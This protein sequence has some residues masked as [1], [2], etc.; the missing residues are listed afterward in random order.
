M[1][2]SCARRRRRHRHGPIVAPLAPERYKVQFTVPRGT[3]DKLR[4]A[5]DLLRHSIPDGDLAAIFDRALTLLLSDLEPAKRAATARPRVSRSAT[6][7]S[8]HIPAG[9]R[10]EVWKRDGGRC[11]FVGT[12]GRCTERGFLEFHH[13]EPYAV[14][15]LAVVQ[16]IELRCRA[17]NLH[18]AE[19]Y[20]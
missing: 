2:R 20:L 10:R 17:H 1:R 13:V 16:N 9:V 19:Q 12:Q 6:S 18:E 3:H 4:R 11:A 5:Q 8:R 15:G 14:G 7:G